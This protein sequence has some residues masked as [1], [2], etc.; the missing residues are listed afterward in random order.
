MRKAEGQIFATEA[1]RNDEGGR[2]IL[3]PAKGAVL[4]MTSYT[5]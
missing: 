3:R 1:Q 4:R 2:E 5:F